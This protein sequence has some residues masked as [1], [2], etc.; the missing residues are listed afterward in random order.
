MKTKRDPAQR[1]ENCARSLA[2]LKKG[3]GRHGGLH[4]AALLL[5]DPTHVFR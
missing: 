1:K 5:D 2:E 3:G 4:D